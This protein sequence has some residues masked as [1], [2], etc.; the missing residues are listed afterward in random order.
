MINKTAEEARQNSIIKI[1]GI[2]AKKSIGENAVFFKKVVAALQKNKIKILF[3]E[4]CAALLPANR[5]PRS[6]A[7]ST[8]GL[9]SAPGISAKPGKPPIPVPALRTGISSKSEILKKSDLAIILGGDGT[10]LKTA[11]C[12]AKKGTPLWGINLGNVGFLTESHPEKFE[13]HLQSI[14]KGKYLLEKRFLL[15]VEHC[16]SGKKQQSFLALNEAVINQGLFA[17][18]IEM[19]VSVDGRPML[20]IKADGVIIST[21]TGSTAHSLSAGGP[22]V[23][24]E[25]NALLINPICPSTLTMRPIIIPNSAKVSIKLATMRHENQNMGL[26][27]DGQV[28]VPLEYGDEIRIRKSTRAFQMVRFPENDYYETLHNKLGW[29]K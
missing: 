23:H 15:R 1:V 11:G 22:I 25:L 4:H 18:L 12:T 2:I 14:L 3:D 5:A 7:A 24:P 19:K 8:P 13:E 28:T 27:M 10:I 21:P 26:T 29:G 16:S 9:S 6:A 20:S 17:R